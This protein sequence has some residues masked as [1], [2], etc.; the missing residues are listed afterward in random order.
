MYLAILSIHIVIC[1]GLIVVVLL[2]SGR[3]AGLSSAFGGGGGGQ[4][5]FGG[6]GAAPFLTKATTVL[7]IAFGLTSLTL[8]VMSARRP[9]Q[10]TT[11]IQQEL[12]KKGVPQP[13]PSS[14]QQQV[15]PTQGQGGAEQM[16]TSP[17]A[18]KGP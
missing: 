9:T 5:V 14:G 10:A 7:A 18:P 6:R 15:P 12:Q 1:L 2:Q 11:A 16:P 17:P 13:T 8:A 3:G 4:A